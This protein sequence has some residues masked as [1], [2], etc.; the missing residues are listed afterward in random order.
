MFRS[1]LGFVWFAALYGAVRYLRLTG[2]HLNFTGTVLDLVDAVVAIWRAL[3]TH[4]FS[5]C[6]DALFAPDMFAWGH[7][8]G[9]P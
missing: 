1:L 8:A 6:S 2:S 7:E 3:P 9:I 5:R 4:S